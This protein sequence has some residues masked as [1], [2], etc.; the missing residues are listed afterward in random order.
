MT[1]FPPS[2]DITCAI[3]FNKTSFRR[4]ES[5]DPFSLIARN[6]KLNL[7]SR[8]QLCLGYRV[9][10]GCLHSAKRMICL[11]WRFLMIHVERKD[12]KGFW[13]VC[14]PGLMMIVKRQDT[15]AL[16]T[17]VSLSLTS[18]YNLKKLGEQHSILAMY[19]N[20]SRNPSCIQDGCSHG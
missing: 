15:V 2:F 7:S 9:Q 8:L 19:S 1:F 17:S 11:S 3:K 10:S 18:F 6:V 16:C 13:L 4:S 14:M 5:T 20:T 12:V